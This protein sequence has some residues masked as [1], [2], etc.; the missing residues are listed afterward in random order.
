M[1]SVI[2]LNKN[3][4]YLTEVNIHKVIKWI[5]KEKIEIVVSKEDEEIRSVE[6]RIKMPMVVRL[7]HFI[8]YKRKGHTVPYSNHSVFARDNNR[9]QYWHHEEN[10]EKYIYQCTV[11]DRTIDHVLPRSRGGIRSYENCVCCCRTCNE[12][13]KKNMTPKEA[14]MELIKIPRAP[15]TKRGDMVVFKFAYNP[16]KLAHKFYMENFLHKKFSRKA[17]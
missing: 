13:K 11:D 14:G 8:G 10:G 9:C 1:H 16:S 12:Q 7:I 17:E 6:F 2:V 15:S 3:F 5:V 4:E